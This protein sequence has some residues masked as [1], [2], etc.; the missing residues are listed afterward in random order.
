MKVFST[1]IA[2]IIGIPRNSNFGLKL[3]LIFYEI[4]NFEI[5]ILHGT[6][7]LCQNIPGIPWNF[8]K[9]TKYFISKGYEFWIFEYFLLILEICCAVKFPLINLINVPN[10]YEIELSR[11]FMNFWWNFKPSLYLVKWNN[12]YIF[13]DCDEMWNSFTY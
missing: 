6:Q 1:D 3:K 5:I 9:P 2:D 4:T 7:V 8:F 10:F 13:K 12:L 11:I